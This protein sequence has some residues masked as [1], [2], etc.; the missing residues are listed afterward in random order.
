MGAPD[1]AINL[2]AAAM[3]IIAIEEYFMVAAIDSAIVQIYDRI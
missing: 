3:A 1:V 2:A